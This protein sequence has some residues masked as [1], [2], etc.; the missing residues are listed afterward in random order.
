MMQQRERSFSFVELRRSLHRIYDSYKRMEVF[1]TVV[2]CSLRRMH[3]HTGTLFICLLF[4]GNQSRRS[5]GAEIE[6]RF[7]M[8]MLQSEQGHKYENNLNLFHSQIV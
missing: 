4:L 1:L 5:I 7:F 8:F 6:G 2:T 3:A